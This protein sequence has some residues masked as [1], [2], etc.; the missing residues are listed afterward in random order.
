LEDPGVQ[1]NTPTAAEVEQA[2]KIIIRQE[3]NIYGSQTL[4]LNKQLNVNY[5]DDR[6]LR[7]FSRLQNADISYDAANPL[8]IPKLSRLCRLIAEDYHR[9]ML[10]S[11]ANQLL[12]NIRQRYW[13][14]QDRLLCKSVL[15]H[16]VICRRFNSAPF[17]Y[18][19]MGPLPKERVTKSPPFTYTG[20]D[21]MGP[22]LTKNAARE[23][24]KRYAVLFTC[25]VTRLVHLEVATDLSAKSFI[26][27]LKRFIA[28][29]G[30]PRKIISDNGTNFQLAELILRNDRSEEEDPS[31]SLYL[32]NHKISWSFIP[33]S[34][35]WMGG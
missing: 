18:P 23:D 20:V 19:N 29:R 26:F 4:M 14:P 16:C 28:R 35:P 34:S 1:T 25:L 31:L 2:E 22:I 24:N 32:A 11:G 27:T 9:S 17:R 15:K 10:H 12:Y 8:H 6:L 30:V 3:Q 13:I 7:K 5:D 21:L 33:P